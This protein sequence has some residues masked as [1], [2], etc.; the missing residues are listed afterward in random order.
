V[1]IRERVIANLIPS[2]SIAQRLVEASREVSHVRGA[3]RHAK[4]VTTTYVRR[5]CHASAK[6]IGD[7]RRQQLDPVV[8]TG[9]YGEVSTNTQ[10]TR[11]DDLSADS[12]IEGT[13]CAFVPGDARP[14][15]DDQRP[16]RRN[17]LRKRW[18]WRDEYC[19]YEQYMAS[20]RG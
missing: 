14:C 19:S 3:N 10:T 18:C 17:A 7:A 4:R 6:V 9:G 15:H 12:D 16:R 8:A 5:E 11:P 1:N 13:V 2:E 20:H